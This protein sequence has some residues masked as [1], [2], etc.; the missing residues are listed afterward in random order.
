MKRYG[1]LVLIILIYML[2]L[3]VAVARAQDHGFL[4]LSYVNERRAE[5]GLQELG[6]SHALADIAAWYNDAMVRTGEF[7]H[8]LYPEEER[9]A[10]FIERVEKRH[11][12]FLYSATNYTDI[13][14]ERS[15]T[16]EPVAPTRV[17]RAFEGSPGHR[18][19][20]YDPEAV[21]IGVDQRPDYNRVVVTYVIAFDRGN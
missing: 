9:D 15:N 4:T 5:L 20:L 12:W 7:R 17:I 10:F 21:Y 1:F 16:T 8:G 6:Y 3:G 14:Y 11:E 19:K 18:D 13:I 2:V